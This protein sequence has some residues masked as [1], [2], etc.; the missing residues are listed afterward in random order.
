M[1][2]GLT[3]FK[4]SVPGYR[5]IASLFRRKASALWNQ[6]KG[7]E[8]PVRITLRLVVSLF[9]GITLVASFFAYYQVREE[10]RSMREEL[11][12]RASI[13]ADSLLAQ[14]VESLVYRR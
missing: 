2:I 3:V 1:F 8:G 11:E 13:L 9:V 5:D 12:R 6:F 10:K 4:V 7:G 14:S